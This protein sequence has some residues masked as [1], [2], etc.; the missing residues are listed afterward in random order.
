M[1]QNAT[2]MRILYANLVC[3]AVM[4]PCVAWMV[5]VVVIGKGKLLYC[6]LE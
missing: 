6:P 5:F 2:F 3:V 1:V 4:A